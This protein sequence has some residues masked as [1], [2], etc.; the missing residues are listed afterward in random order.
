[1]FKK[2]K[3]QPLD[4]KVVPMQTT[5]RTQINLMTDLMTCGPNY[6][7]FAG[8]STVRNFMGELRLLQQWLNKY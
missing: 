7:F 8:D 4:Q 5:T 3:E 2:G 6:F 1:V